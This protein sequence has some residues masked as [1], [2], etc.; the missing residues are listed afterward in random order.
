MLCIVIW[1]ILWYTSLSNGSAFL[2]RVPT[3]VKLSSSEN[4]SFVIKLL[5][6]SVNICKHVLTE[7]MRTFG[8]YWNDD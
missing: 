8:V 1:D 2:Y 5:M 7:S 3:S 4:M 6:I